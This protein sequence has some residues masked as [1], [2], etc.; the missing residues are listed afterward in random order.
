MPELYHT[1]T[2]A[3]GFSELPQYEIRGYKIYLF[4]THL[5]GYNDLPSM[6]SDKNS[7]AY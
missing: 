2:H 5:D 6:L 3:K 4:A 7:T 1:E